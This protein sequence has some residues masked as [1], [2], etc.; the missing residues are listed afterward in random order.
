MRP[1]FG[2]RIHDH[3]FAPTNAATAGPSPTTSARRWSSGSRGS[4]STT[5]WSASTGADSGMLYIDI[6]YRIR[7]TN[8]P[9]NLVFPFYVIPEHDAEPSS[10]VGSADGRELTMVLPAPN[11]DDRHFQDLVDDAKR[12]VQQRCPE[13]TDHNVSDP[14]RHAD[15]GVR[16]DG[17]PADLPAEPGA[18]PALH[19]VPRADRRASSPAG[20]GA[21]QGDVLAVGAAAADR[22]GPRRDRGGHAAHRCRRPGGLLHGRGPGHR[23]VLVRTGP[24]RSPADGASQPTTPGCWPR[25]PSVGVLPRSPRAGRRAADRAVAT[26]CRRARW[27]CGWTAPSAAS[28]STRATRRW[29]GRRGPA[30]AGAPARSTATRPA[31]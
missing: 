22:R 11:L 15:R 6:R 14:G 5:C 12:L 28:A 31:G 18:G 29:S 30:P 19:Q 25:A 26:P 1:E 27:C 10:D 13:W 2:C 9:R 8:D 20:G 16:A 21:R 24:A 17:R 7:G 4:T 23:A 3:V